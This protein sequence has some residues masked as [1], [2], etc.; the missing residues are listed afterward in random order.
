MRYIQLD[1]QEAYIKLDPVEDYIKLDPVTTA[2]E[3]F[4]RTATAP[5]VAAAAKAE[6]TLQAIGGDFTQGLG[7]LLQYLNIIP[8]PT[9]GGVPR[10][11]TKDP[12]QA[13]RQ[14]VAQQHVKK[15]REAAAEHPVAGITGTLAG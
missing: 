8:E 11:S 12:L 4:V 1:P 6:D 7:E 13:Q 2:S 9:G 10:Y 3:A 14:T 15:A 5:T